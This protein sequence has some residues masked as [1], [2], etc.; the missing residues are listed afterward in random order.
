MEADIDKNEM[1]KTQGN[2]ISG[3]RFLHTYYVGNSSGSARKKRVS[4]GSVCLLLCF[5]VL[6][7]PI[8]MCTYV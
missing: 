2:E 3:D 6:K 5:N 1:L 4:T 8:V 7:F